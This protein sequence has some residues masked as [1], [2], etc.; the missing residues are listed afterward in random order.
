MWIFG[1]GTS[2]LKPK[3]IIQAPN[4]LSSDIFSGL[5]PNHVMRNLGHAQKKGVW[6]PEKGAGRGGRVVCHDKRGN[7]PY[8][9]LI[10]Q[11]AQ[12]EANPARMVV[13]GGRGA[14]NPTKQKKCATIKARRGIPPIVPVLAYSRGTTR[15]TKQSSH[16]INYAPQCPPPINANIL[17]IALTFETWED[18]KW[19]YR[20]NPYP[21][22]LK[23]QSQFTRELAFCCPSW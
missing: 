9:R 7:T 3:R 16:P 5:W 11:N 8:V 22:L 4:H 15:V 18:G 23:Q 19:T 13:V 1:R 10:L 21:P 14:I 2:N 17:F 12:K 6:P 20:K